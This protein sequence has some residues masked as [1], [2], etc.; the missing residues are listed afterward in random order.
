MRSRRAMLYMP[1]D[2]WRK[3]QK[4][5]GLDVDSICMDMEDGVALNRKAE[6]RGSIR[7]ALGELD[8][9]RSERLARI[10]PVG[11]GLESQ[12][13]TAVLPG[14]PDGIVIPK[15]E[16]AAQITWVSTQIAG[17]EREAGWQPGEI[18]L[19]AIVETARGGCQPEGD[20]RGR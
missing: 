18:R 15:V 7:E 17:P 4:A 1:G 11:S 20:C 10:N 8:F 19:L 12:D 5:A 14:R 16:E 9:G 3:I 13:L 6:A 2:D